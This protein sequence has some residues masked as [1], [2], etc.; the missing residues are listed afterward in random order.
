MEQLRFAFCKSPF[1]EMNAVEGTITE[2]GD[3]LQKLSNNES[4][5]KKAVLSRKIG[6]DTTNDK[7]IVNACVN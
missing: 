1:M 3:Y 6:F 5:S 7:L 4:D 2:A